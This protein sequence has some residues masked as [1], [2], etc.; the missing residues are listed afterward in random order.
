M[1]ITKS[2]IIFFA[3]A[4]TYNLLLGLYLKDFLVPS[5]TLTVSVIHAF[6]ADRAARKGCENN[7]IYYPGARYSCELYLF[8]MLPQIAPNYDDTFACR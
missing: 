3:I 6:S 5:Q 7:R 2:R 1:K 4:L 8:C